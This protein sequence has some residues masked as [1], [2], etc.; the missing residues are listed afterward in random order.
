MLYSQLTEGLSQLFGVE[1]AVNMLADAGFPAVDISMF[2][3]C[4]PPHC[5]GWRELAKR[6]AKV[7]NERGIKYVQSHAP[8][9]TI[10]YTLENIVPKLDDVFECA[11]ML[12]IPYVVIH[13]LKDR[14]YFVDKS[15]MFNRNL[16][17]YS[18]LAPR[19]KAHG[20]KIAIENMI[21]H[22]D[23]ATVAS[24]CSDPHELAAMYDTL[25]DPSVFTLCLDTGHSAI[26]GVEPED[27]IRILGRDRLGCLHIHDNDYVGDL[28]LMC[29]E[30][31]INWDNVCRSLG[32]I[33]YGG[34]LTLEVLGSYNNYTR[35]EIPAFLRSMSQTAKKMCEKIDFH[36]PNAR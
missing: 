10:E 9:G 11:A 26:A 6:L 30:G 35:E 16:E 5:D 27:A 21:T 25:N 2:D 32:E 18:S 34:V 13:P 29:G 4:E 7:A 15:I 1:N 17:Y 14:S 23:G 8:F 19:A 36:R 22:V 31:K 3:P 12:G 28:H 20:V 33:D 24:V